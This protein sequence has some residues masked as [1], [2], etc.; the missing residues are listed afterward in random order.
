MAR[1]EEIVITPMTKKQKILNAFKII[2]ICF[3]A[4]FGLVA[5][6]VLYVW[7]T[8]GFNPPYVPLTEMSF[9]QAEYVI[10]DLDNIVLV[11]NEGCTELDDVTLTIEDTDIVAL[12]EDDYTTAIR[13]NTAEEETQD[14]QTET[15]IVDKYKVTIGKNIQIIPVKQTINAGTDEEKQINVG[16]WVKLVAERN[17]IQTE[18]WVFVDVPVESIDLVVNSELEQAEPEGEEQEITYLVYPNSKINLSV[19]NQQPS[20]SFNTPASMLSTGIGKV[21]TGFINKKYIKFVGTEDTLATVNADTGEV[22]VKPNVQGSFYVYAYVVSAYNNIGKEPVYDDY[23]KN[24]GESE[25]FINWE[26]DFDKIRVKTQKIKFKIQDIAIDSLNVAKE[27]LQFNLLSNNNLVQVNYVNTSTNTIDSAHSNIYHYAVDIDLNFDNNTKGILY[28]N[29]ILKSGYIDNSDPNAILINGKNIVLDDTYIKISSPT[30]NYNANPRQLSWSVVINEYKSSGNVLVFGYPV[31]D[32]DGQVINYVYDYAEVE[33][34]K[35]KIDSLTFNNVE[36]E[37]NLSWNDVPDNVQT[38]DLNNTVAVNPTNATYNNSSYLMYFALSDN[39]IIEVDDSIKIKTIDNKV[40][41]AICKTDGAGNKTYNIINPIN[42]GSKTD[43]AAVVLM[44]DANGELID[45][46]GYYK[47]DYIGNLSDSISVIVSKSLKVENVDVLD[48]NDNSIVNNNQVTIS[49]GDA[50]VIEITCDD[51]VKSDSEFTW[52]IE[53]DGNQ[54][55]LSELKREKNDNKLKFTLTSN[56][57]AEIEIYIADAN[58]NKISS[59]SNISLTILNTE[60]QELALS[61]NAQNGVSVKLTSDDYA[62]KVIDENGNLTNDDLS[63]SV[64]YNPTNTNNTSFT[65][66][67]YQCNKDYTPEELAQLK[68]TDLFAYPSDILTFEESYDD[69]SATSFKPTINK[70]GKAIVF[71]VSLSGDIVSNPILIEITLPKIVVEFSEYGN[72]QEIIATDGLTKSLVTYDTID[73]TNG[74]QGDKYRIGI[75][76]KT[77]DTSINAGKTYYLFEDGKYIAV[78]TP[79]NVYINDYFEFVDISKLVTYKFAG[80][81]TQADGLL[82]SGSGTKIDNNN[83]TLILCDIDRDVEETVVMTTEFGFESDSSQ[84]FTYKL[85]ADYNVVTT[86]QEYYAPSIV[87][88]FGNYQEV[89]QPDVSDLAT[90]YELVGEQYVITTDISIADGKTYYKQVEPAVKFTNKA[91]TILYL[92][93]GYNINNL[94]KDYRNQFVSQVAEPVADEIASYYEFVDGDYIK[95]SDTTIDA[96]KTYYQYNI[97]F[98]LNISSLGTYCSFTSD[99]KIRIYGVPQ[100]DSITITSIVGV[101]KED[102]NLGYIQD[103]TFTIKPAVINN[104]VVNDL[105]SN[106]NSILSVQTIIKE[107]NNNEFDGN[108]NVVSLQDK[109]N[110]TVMNNSIVKIKKVEFSFGYVS[111]VGVDVFEGNKICKYQKTTDTTVDLGKTY[112]VKNSTG[113]SKVEIASDDELASYYEI[114]SI[115][116]QLD[117]DAENNAWTVILCNN[118]LENDIS[119]FQL[120]LKVE[121]TITKDGIT[122]KKTDYYTIK[123]VIPN[124]N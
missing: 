67:S 120:K 46:G 80:E 37:I 104:F 85:I 90:Y 118:I 76:S 63:F 110:Y 82:I 116:A 84:S 15:Q 61:T 75:Y 73:E 45:D 50:F 83:K 95:T 8:G 79:S 98:V 25:G 4:V 12:V 68:P 43:I 21:E 1:N 99:G 115:Y 16:G 47:F 60:L 66:A 72:N 101:L 41:S 123:F 74:R 3:G 70:A 32:D 91:G 7:A 2:G 93:R 119:E 42:Y 31:F 49:K 64:A 5:G 92:P 28:E 117:Y 113:F 35:V 105:D 48:T 22:S 19:A 124:G 18:C 26:Q 121:A 86:S 94:T 10:S 88:V 23:I 100:E 30:I 122:T 96:T 29:L 34:N 89:L 6:I 11:P 108:S 59:I 9:S 111:M 58:G 13:Q 14:D 109:L 20:T 65:V 40:Y 77:T 114:V 78:E 27:V 102:D 51:V 17:L 44:Y 36:K 52:A 39:G 33:I 38:K 56:S 62:W 55:V 81:Y 97:K 57:D 112:Y 107:E 53:G 106:K 71:A 87:D 103:F 69:S 54:S 24:Y